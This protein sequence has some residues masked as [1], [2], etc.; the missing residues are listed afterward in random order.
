MTEIELCGQKLILYPQ[1]GMYWV[2]QDT[3][4]ITDTHL[5]KGAS[6]R[7][8]GIPV[9]ASNTRSTLSR[10]SSLIDKTS[11]SRLIILGDF[12]HARESVSPETTDIIGTWRKNYRLLE[13]I[14]VVGNH[15]KMSGH[16]PEELDIKLYDP[17][18]TQHPFSFTHEPSD[19]YSQYTLSGHI[20]P[21]VSLYENRRSKARFPCFYF[22][23][24][25][26][27]LPAFGDFT[28]CHDIKPGSKDRIYIITPENVIDVTPSG[29]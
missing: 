4:I 18:M 13:T 22:G 20:H 29:E 28:G 27:L 26:A 5:G 10:L 3:L 6:F 2:E 21:S 19:Q 8:N 15:D 24:R 9:P 1:K 14:L 17:V 25:Y 16:P 23:E 11:A 7:A 12:Y